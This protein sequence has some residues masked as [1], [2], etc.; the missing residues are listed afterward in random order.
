MKKSSVTMNAP[1]RTIAIASHA[2]AARRAGA[3]AVWVSEPVVDMADT[4]A[5]RRARVDYLWGS[6]DDRGRPWTRTRPAR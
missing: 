3:A 5:R 2:G 1:Q 6:D 4:V